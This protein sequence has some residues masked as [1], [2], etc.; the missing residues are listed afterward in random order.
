MYFMV[1][2]GSMVTKFIDSH[3]CDGGKIYDS[4]NMKLIASNLGKIKIE[5]EVLI[6]FANKFPEVKLF[7]SEY[8]IQ[9]VED[10]LDLIGKGFIKY[11]KESFQLYKKEYKGYLQSRGLSFPVEKKVKPKEE[12]KK[13]ETGE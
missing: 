13:G 11:P 5:D 12:P 3:P 6:N 4:Q 1:E 9:L 8:E 7:Q 2:R 10:I